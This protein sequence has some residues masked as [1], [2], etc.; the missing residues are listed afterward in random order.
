M[1]FT[2][3]KNII[4]NIFK[5]ETKLNKLISIDV[6]SDT[7]CPWCYIGYKRLQNVIDSF[8]KY[9]FDI[10][11]RPFQ[12]NPEMNTKGLDRQDYLNKKFGNKDNAHLIYKRIEEEGIKIGI[13]FQFNKIKVTPNSFLSHKLLAYAHKKKKQTQVLESIFYQYFIEGN[14]IGDLKK[15]LEIAKQTKIYDN[16]IENYLLSSDD[17]NNILNEEKYARDIGITGVPC[18][19]LN[20]E[21]VLN[22]AQ[23]EENF[24]QMIESIVN[25][26]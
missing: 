18:F 10:T 8:S 12:L 15:L 17:S 13:H 14:N 5:K 21:F 23:S 1:Y 20:K 6:F 22:G 25:N 2:K 9:K 4:K 24:I 7:I 19:I 3:Q 16:D 26:E 11:W